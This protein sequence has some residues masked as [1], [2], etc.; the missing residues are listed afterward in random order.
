M[1]PHCREAPKKIRNG[2]AAVQVRSLHQITRRNIQKVLDGVVV[3]PVLFGRMPFRRRPWIGNCIPTPWLD[4]RSTNGPTNDAK[5]LRLN[6]SHWNTIHDRQYSLERILVVVSN[7]GK[8][9]QCIRNLLAFRES[10]LLCQYN[11]YFMEQFRI[12][13]S[14]LGSTTSK[15][16]QLLTFETE[17]RGV[18]LL[19]TTQTASITSFLSPILLSVRRIV[20]PPIPSIPS[21]PSG[22]APNPTVPI[23]H[24]EL[25]TSCGQKLPG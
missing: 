25:L 12:M 3:S 24:T 15:I 9:P 18:T 21:R 14:Q 10:S 1:E 4:T 8:G 5:V 20:L 11:Q 19:V 17:K 2:L 13:I 22:S 7:S 16:A 6:T 23:A